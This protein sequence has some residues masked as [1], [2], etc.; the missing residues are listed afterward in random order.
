MAEIATAVTHTITPTT[1]EL[2]SLRVG[3]KTALDTGHGTE[4]ERKPV[5]ASP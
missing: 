2:K 3:M 4:I 1:D 5:A